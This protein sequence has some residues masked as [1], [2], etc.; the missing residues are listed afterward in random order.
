M[1]NRNSSTDPQVEQEFIPD[2]GSIKDKTPGGRDRVKAEAD[3]REF[4]QNVDQAA[5]ALAKQRRSDHGAGIS[6]RALDTEEAEQD[7]L[8]ERNTRKPR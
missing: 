6:N 8:P 7:E 3:E 2:Q 5:E 1:P 4:A